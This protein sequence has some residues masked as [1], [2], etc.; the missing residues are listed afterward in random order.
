M[1]RRIKRTVKLGERSQSARPQRDIRKGERPAS[2]RP[3]DKQA[4]SGEKRGAY[5]Q[6]RRPKP[7]AHRKQEPPPHPAEERVIAKAEVPLPTKS[8]ETV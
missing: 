5:R 4:R 2:Q 8:H 6:E 3:G 7:D 1:S